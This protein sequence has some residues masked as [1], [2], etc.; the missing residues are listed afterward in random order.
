MFWPEHCYA[1]SAAEQTS[2]LTNRNYTAIAYIEDFNQVE[3]DVVQQLE[4]MFK[5]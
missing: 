1:K 5:A 4:I 2:Q 3:F